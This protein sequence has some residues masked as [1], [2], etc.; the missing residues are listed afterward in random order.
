MQTGLRVL[1]GAGLIL[2]L[3]CGKS[4]AKSADDAKS[5]KLPSI[6]QQCVHDAAV[7]REPQPNPPSSVV[8]SHILVRHVDLDRPMGAK[9]TRQD[10][11]RRA[12]EALHA[13]KGGMSWT[14]A[15]HKYSDAPGPG[16]GELGSIKKEDA[17]PAFAG[18]A[19]ALDVN[20]LSYV[21]ESKRGYHVILRTE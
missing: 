13:L 10:A 18:A 14:E 5:E 6:E 16:D 3:G 1:L 8:V 7:R 4:P 21:V 20:E 17:D 11:C 15:V 12:L 9:R 19:F 2:S